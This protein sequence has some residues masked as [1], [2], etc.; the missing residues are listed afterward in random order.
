MEVGSKIFGPFFV[1]PAR[2]SWSSDAVGVFVGGLGDQPLCSLS[3]C[4]AS[5]TRVARALAESLGGGTSRPLRNRRWDPH[6]AVSISATSEAT[7]PATDQRN[8]ASAGARRASQ[9]A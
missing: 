9:I 7:T 8:G 1:H 5:F 3:G 6:A 2:V 4:S